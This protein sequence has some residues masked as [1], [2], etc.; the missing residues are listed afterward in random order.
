MKYI[1]NIEINQTVYKT[2]TSNKNNRYK[3]PQ[4]E[5]QDCHCLEMVLD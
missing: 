4:N 2:K 5:P 1:N 3:D